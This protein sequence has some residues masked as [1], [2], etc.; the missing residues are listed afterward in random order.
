VNT[1]P[2][3][4][5]A[6]QM[7][8]LEDFLRFQADTLIQVLS[9]MRER[10]GRQ[11]RKVSASIFCDPL[12][13]RRLRGLINYYIVNLGTPDQLIY[14]ALMIRLI[15]PEAELQLNINMLPGTRNFSLEMMPEKPM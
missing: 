13:F 4:Q 8:G 9:E 10:M 12:P 6:F 3:I 11:G 15:V 7:K 5:M 14:Q 1:M 2:F